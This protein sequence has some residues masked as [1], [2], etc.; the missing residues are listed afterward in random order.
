MHLDTLKR[1]DELLVTCGGCGSGKGFALKM[2]PKAKEMKARSKGVWDSAGDQSATEN[3]WIQEEAEHRGLKVNYL[4]VHAD[5]KVQWADPN[6]AKENRPNRGII[7][8]AADPTDGRMV[9]A[10]IAAQSYGNGARNMQ[11]FVD[12]NGHNPHASFTYLQNSGPKPIELP[13]IPKEALQIDT[14]ELANFMIEAV[15]KSNA[16]A[17]VQRGALMDERLFRG[18]YGQ[19]PK[20]QPARSVQG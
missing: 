12:H 18:Q 20:P 9:G 7:S 11:A 13:G 8:R 2:I 10:V 16:P 19:A 17:W 5:P 14:R 15:K 4:Y 3:P 6:A 1:G